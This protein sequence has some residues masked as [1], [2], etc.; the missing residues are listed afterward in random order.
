MIRVVLSVFILC[1]FSIVYGQQGDGGH[2]HGLGFYAKD[3]VSSYIFNEPNLAL[4]RAE[5]KINDSLQ[6]GPWRFGYNYETDLDLTNSGTWFTTTNGDKI[7]L[8]EI[9]MKNA[10]S[11]NLTFKNSDIPNGNEL[12]IYNPTGD[13]VLGKFT[14]KH[15][16]QGALGAELVYGNTVIVEYFVPAINASNLGNINIA[17]ATYGYR[18]QEEFLD[19]AFGSSGSCQMNV[20]CPDGLPYQDQRNSAVMIVSGSNGFCSGATINNT[21]ND[22][23]PYVLTANHCWTSHQ[24][25]TTWIFRFNWQA[26][27]CSNPGSSPSFE[28]L[29][30]AVLRAKRK[31]SDFCLVEI[32]GGLDNGIIPAICNPFMAG[33]DN[34]NTPPP[35]TFC[36][37]HPKGDIKKI[38]FDDNP[39]V[40]ADYPNSTHEFENSWIVVWDRNTAT[41][42]ASS[43]SPLY[44]HKGRIIGQLWGGNS[45]C[46]NTGIGYDYYGRLHNSWNPAGSGNDEQLKYWLDPSGTDA[47]S[48]P[49]YNPYETT[50]T[51]D[52]AAIEFLNLSDANCRT[53]FIPEVLIQNKGND[54]L[55]SLTVNYT[56]NNGSPQSITWTGN[57]PTNQIDTVFLPLFTSVNGQ[58]DIS[59]EL[60][61]PNGST[62]ENIS[63]DLINAQ[64]NVNTNGYLL[65]FVFNLGCFAEETSWNLANSLGQPLYSGSNYPGSYNYNY[66]VEKEF[67]LDEGCYFLTLID[68]YGDGVSG[69]GLGNCNYTGSMT[70]TEVSS[71]NIL[72]ELPEAD[73][74]FGSSITYKVCVGP[75]SI[76]NQDM[77]EKVTIYPNPATNEFTIRTSLSGVKS[78]ALQNMLGQE[79]LSLSTTNTETNIQTSQFSKGVYLV[80]II[81]EKGT[82]TKKLILE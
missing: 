39:A 69:A 15:L 4:L 64:F 38:S 13:F 32:T 78:I 43:G 51:V 19:K 22:G 7:W 34:S 62:D 60:S 75:A 25:V 6:N 45:S 8:L 35:S 37:H 28:S 31:P 65:D 82:I 21:N 72:A 26:P 54:A 57:L 50:F 52:A 30:G 61:N 79:V 56:Y 53:D 46:A 49:G 41:E 10:Q 70:L 14:R 67:C 20:N 9:K 33:W 29:S 55:T 16:Y 1:V 2:P 47:N 42:S 17:R 5:D 76:D 48:I 58:N 71:G 27:T 59:I 63:N 74:D 68:A 24:D 3:N 80:H 73:A 23:T 44:N 81:S 66:K 36:I 40:A 77:L 18:S 12:Y 11:I